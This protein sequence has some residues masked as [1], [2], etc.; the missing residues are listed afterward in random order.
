MNPQT[1]QLLDN[2]VSLQI[3]EGVYSDE[4]EAMLEIQ[5]YINQQKALDSLLEKSL[6]SGNI[7]NYSFNEMKLRVQ[8]QLEKNS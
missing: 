3:H 2:L 5:E 1:K 4:T 6:E 8:E 7:K